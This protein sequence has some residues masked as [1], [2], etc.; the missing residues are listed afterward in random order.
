MSGEL[1][2][3]NQAKWWNWIEERHLTTRP[4][5]TDAVTTRGRS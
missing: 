5:V 4:V 3:I 1:L 2:G